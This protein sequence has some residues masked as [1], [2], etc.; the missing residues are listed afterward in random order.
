M[1]EYQNKIYYNLK[2]QQLKIK[3]NCS[4]LDDFA[5]KSKKINTKIINHKV[6]GEMVSHFAENGITFIDANN[7]ILLYKNL[8]KFTT[9]T[10]EFGCTRMIEEED[11]K[12][13]IITLKSFSFVS[14]NSVTIKFYGKYPFK[15][16]CAYDFNTNKSV[17][18]TPSKRKYKNRSHYVTVRLKLN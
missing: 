3:I 7:V 9:K 11:V 14:K 10:L 15:G 2:M 18:I 16:N 4:N 8:D 13:F 5:F 6:F 12:N 1:N 17:E